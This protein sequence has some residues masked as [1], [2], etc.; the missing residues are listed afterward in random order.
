MNGDVQSDISTLV[1]K[2][3]EQHEDFHSRILRIQQEIILS[4]EIVSPNRLL[5]QYMKAL[6]NSDKLR[7]FI[8]PKMTDL[9]TFLDNN[10]KS[11]VYEGEN[12]HGIYRYL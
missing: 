12:I 1:F 2:N 10:G 9:I 4:G 3:G 11:A 8:A 7:V 6:S 5:F